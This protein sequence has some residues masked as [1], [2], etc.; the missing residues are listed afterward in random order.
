MMTD[1]RIRD[2]IVAKG[3]TKPIK[4][5]DTRSVPTEYKWMIYRVVKPIGS[6]SANEVN[7][8]SGVL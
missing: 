2:Y 1:D 4:R 8:T 7:S 3:T 5:T 6:M